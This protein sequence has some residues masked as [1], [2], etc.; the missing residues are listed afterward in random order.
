[1]DPLG[2]KIRQP[3]SA[4]LMQKQ[5]SG[6]KT[7]QEPSSRLITSSMSTGTSSQTRLGDVT[8]IPEWLHH[9]RE[10]FRISP[11]RCWCRVAPAG[12]GKRVSD[13]EY[14]SRVTCPEFKIRNEVEHGP[15]GI[16]IR[17]GERRSPATNVIRYATEATTDERDAA[18]Q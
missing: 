2:V 8:G 14:L 6:E 4:L 16:A 13:S 11:N 17:A 1:M 10:L 7:Y 18:L 3:D 15:L 5:V 12:P 9:R